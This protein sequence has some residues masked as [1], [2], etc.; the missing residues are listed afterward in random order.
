DAAGKINLYDDYDCNTPSTLN[1]TVTLPLSTCLVTTGGGG[2]VIDQTPPCPQGTATLIY[3]Q[4]PACGLAD[5]TDLYNAKA[6]MFSCQPA[7]NNPEPSSTSTAVVSALA[8]VATGSTGSNGSGG[9][10]GSSTSAAGGSTPTDTSTQQNSTGGSTSTSTSTSNNDSGTSSGSGFD[11][12]DIIALAVGLGIGIPTIVIML[13]TW[14]MP[15]FRHKLRDW[16]SSSGRRV[17]PSAFQQHHNAPLRPQWERSFDRQEMIP[18][19][20]HSHH[21]Y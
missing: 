3:Y 9:G 5:G 18:Q 19:Q 1:P 8:A 14:L 13:A 11:T 4:D 12:G 6:V 17:T 7:E 16:F 20:Q 10:S 15:N 21:P 2:L